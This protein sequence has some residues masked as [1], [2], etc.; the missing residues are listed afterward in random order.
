MSNIIRF[1]K[2][3]G[4]G[5]DFILFDAITQPVYLY[6]RLIRMLAD[7]HKGIGCDQVLVVEPPFQPDHDFF[8]RIF[9]ADGKEVEQCGNGARC[10]ARFV[11]EQGLTSKSRLVL[12]TRA[13]PVNVNFRS[14]FSISVDMGKPRFEFKSPEPS[15]QSPGFFKIDIHGI[16]RRMVALSFGNPHAVLFS[17]NI[18]LED[19]SGIGQSLQSHPLFVEGVNVSFVE[20]QDES[21]LR[22]RTYERGVGETLACGSGACASAC[23]KMLN[24]EVSRKVRVQMP[25]GHVFVYW[26]NPSSSVFLTGPATHVFQGQIRINRIKPLPRRR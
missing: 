19:V 11:K 2:M 10:F 8:Y 3:H 4:L 16:Q 20:H 26:K 25:G 5:N 15:S 7:R 22:I 13:G 18:D 1:S 6:P 14:P 23:A 24:R 12:G 17:D 9:N 21:T